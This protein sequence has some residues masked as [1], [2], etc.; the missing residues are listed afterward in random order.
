MLSCT[1]RPIHLVPH[2]IFIVTCILLP[3]QLAKHHGCSFFETSALTGEGVPETFTKLTKEI[4]GDEE[5][6]QCA[7]HVLVSAVAWL[8]RGQHYIKGLPVV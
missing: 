4:I 8:V 3:P 5:V 7:M 6:R 2:P 1:V